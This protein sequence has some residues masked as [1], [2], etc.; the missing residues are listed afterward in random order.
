MNRIVIPVA[1]AFLFSY[2]LANGSDAEG[3]V[4]G[5]APE[6]LT[7]SSLVFYSYAEPDFI[8]YYSETSQI[9]NHFAY[10]LSYNEEFE[11]ADWVAY[12]LTDEMLS[13]PVC[14][15][16]DSFKKDPLV[17]TG[18]ASASDYKNSGYSK[19]HL[20]PAADMLLSETAMKESFYFSNMS[21]QKQDFNNGIWKKLEEQVREWARENE[22]VFVVTGPVLDK[23]SYPTIGKNEVAVPEKF[24]KVILDYTEPEIKLSVSSYHTKITTR[25]SR[26]SPSR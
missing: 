9:I 21:P 15:R 19:G 18:S 26:C 2:S 16:D 4:S 1:V 14:E 25:T 5:D 6:S 22:E 12:R 20:A 23:E 10:S 24:Y 3:V 11:Q 8:I 7:P 17:V 13:N